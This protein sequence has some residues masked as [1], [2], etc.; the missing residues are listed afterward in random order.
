MEDSK[1]IMNENVYNQIKEIKKY[2]LDN[3]IPIM[4]DRGIDFLT[5]FIVDHQVENILE[6]GTAIGYSSIM[7]ALSS[8]NVKITTIERDQERYME[9]VKNIK[10][11]GLED[12]I[13]L[14]FNDALDVEVDGTFDLIFL[15]AAKGQNIRFFEKFEKNLTE[16]GTIITDNMDFHGL[17]NQEEESMSRNLR[18]LIRKIK[19]YQEFLE[20]NENYDVKF[21]TTGDGIAVAHRK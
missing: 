14:I 9:A 18:G 6:V 20:N 1:K 21:L 17:V 2:A 8:P 15:D 10:K 4:V 12:R 11:M 3:K 13:T 5:R 7:M 19:E 16:H